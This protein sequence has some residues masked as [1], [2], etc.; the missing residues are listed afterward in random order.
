MSNNLLK[1]DS[2]QACY[3]KTSANKEG[4]SLLQEHVVHTTDHVLR[5]IE[6]E[7]APERY[8]V[9][10]CPTHRKHVM[11]KICKHCKKTFCKRCDTRKKCPAVNETTGGRTTVYGVYEVVDFNC[12]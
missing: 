8:E 10:R 6:D 1:L 11:E 9:E 4:K 7:P 3:T 5:P 12:L 2:R